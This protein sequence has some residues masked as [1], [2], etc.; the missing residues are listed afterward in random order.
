MNVFME[1]ESEV[2]QS[3][4][5]LCDPMDCSL[6]GSSVHG[7]FQAI[8]LEWIAIFF[9]SGSSRPRDRTHVS[10]LPGRFFTTEPSGM[11]RRQIVQSFFSLAFIVWLFQRL[12]GNNLKISLFFFKINLR[13]EYGSSPKIHQK[14]ERRLV[15]S[16]VTQCQV[17]RKS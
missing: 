13:R 3:C 15:E 12:K 11:A 17:L 14:G 2:A 16:S 1:S 9:S 6:S 4:L 10:C 8:V 7:I 5:T